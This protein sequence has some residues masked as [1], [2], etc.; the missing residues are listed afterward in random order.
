MG[1][2]VSLNAN[3]VLAEAERCRREARAKVETNSFN[4]PN[5]FLSRLVGA[6]S[7]KGGF[8]R[9]STIR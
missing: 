7:L 8:G 3:E 6:L 1:A 9:D 2:I 4:L 5:C